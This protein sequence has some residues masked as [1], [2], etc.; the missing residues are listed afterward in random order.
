MKRLFLIIFISFNVF[1]QKSIKIKGYVIEDLKTN[2]SIMFHKG[3]LSLNLYETASI[4]GYVENNK[5]EIHGV[6]SYPQMYYLSFYSENSTIPHRQEVYFIDS[7]TKRINISKSTN[8]IKKNNSLSLE[9]YD[10][11]MPFMIENVEVSFLKFRHTQP[12]QFDI[13]IKEYIIKNNNSYVALW[14]LAERINSQGY[15]NEYSEI[16]NYFSNT[17]KESDLWHK[18][19]NEL[20]SIQIR[21]G[22]NFPLDLVLKDRSKNAIVFKLPKSKYVLVDFWFSRC[23][24]CLSQLPQLKEIYKTYSPLE[25]DVV[26]ISVDKTQDIDLWNKRIEEKEI[27]WNNYLDENGIF[28]SK[29]K[30]FSFPTNYLLDQNGVVIRKNISFEELIKIVSGN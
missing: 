12:E 4:K 21:I 18:V 29:E 19:R 9:Y 1:S 30:I 25:L 6:F 23:K 17:I 27:P 8:D 3:N 15:K 11:F 16:L 24:P 28:S 2:D 5:F 14:S 22:K 13:K 7:N 10:K 20:D 26:G